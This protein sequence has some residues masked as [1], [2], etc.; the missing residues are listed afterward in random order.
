MTW[1]K[2]SN[3]H[4][5]KSEHDNSK[6]DQERVVIRTDMTNKIRND[7]LLNMAYKLGEHHG[8]D[9]LEI[10]KRFTLMLLE[11]KDEAFQEKLDKVMN[12]PAPSVIY[13]HFQ[14]DV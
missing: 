10:L 13:R 3:T 4:L 11:L 9:E 8:F 7:Y 2:D 14:T 6:S 1:L 12:S 5:N